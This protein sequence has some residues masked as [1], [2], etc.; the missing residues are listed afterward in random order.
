M[1][2]LSPRPNNPNLICFQ[3]PSNSTGLGQGRCLDGTTTTPEEHCSET[4]L[5]SFPHSPQ[6]PADCWLCLA[7][8]QGCLHGNLL[9]IAM[10]HLDC[11]ARRSDSPGLHIHKLLHNIQICNHPFALFYLFAFCD[12]FLFPGNGASKKEEILPCLSS[13]EASVSS[14]IPAGT[15]IFI[16]PCIL[17]SL[18]KDLFQGWRGFVQEEESSKPQHTWKN[19]VSQ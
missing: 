12:L 7:P 10:R 8:D 16:F 2:L 6:T 5:R 19:S 11:D 18:W 1:W 9:C 3:P 17:C 13:T 4:L 15:A 14:F